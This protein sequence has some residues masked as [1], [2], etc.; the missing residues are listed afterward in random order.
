MDKINIALCGVEDNTQSI[1]KLRAEMLARTSARTVDGVSADGV[2]SFGRVSGSAVV[3]TFTGASCELLFGSAAVGSGVSP[4]IAALP[5]GTD[6]L[7]LTASR[8]GA[9]ALI[10]G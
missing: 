4:I 2:T 6:S 9:K 5:S 3:V 1:L 8:S 7:A 10:I